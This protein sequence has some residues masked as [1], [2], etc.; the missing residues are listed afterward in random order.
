ME[1]GRPIGWTPFSGTLLLLLRSR[2]LGGGSAGVLVLGLDVRSD[3]GEH[4]L[5]RFGELAVRLQLQM[6]LELFGG[7]AYR[8]GLAIRRNGRLAEQIQ[9]VLIVGVG[10]VGIRSD[11]LLKRHAGRFQLVDVSQNRAHVVVVAAGI[12]RVE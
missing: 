10:I 7:D 8:Y 1:K 4:A 11:G 6:L 9:A 2:L 5:G 12:W 3:G